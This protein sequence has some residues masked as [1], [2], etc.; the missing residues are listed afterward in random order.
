MTLLLFHSHLF[1]TVDTLVRMSLFACLIQ[2]TKILDES[3]DQDTTDLH[4]CVTYIRDFTPDV[5]KSNV[6]YIIIEK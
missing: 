6:S 5:E 4:K 3:H 2:G 1:S